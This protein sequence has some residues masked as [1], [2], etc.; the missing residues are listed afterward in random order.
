MNPL[1][2]IDRRFGVYQVV[3]AVAKRVISYNMKNIFFEM[4]NISKRMSEFKC[5]AQDTWH[6]IVDLSRT[7]ISIHA[8]K[9][10]N[11]IYIQAKVLPP[12]K[13]S[14]VQFSATTRNAFS[15][16]TISTDYHSVP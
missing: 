4:L 15:I 13:A 5:I 3:V 10:G 12:I 11:P 1:F 6:M 14:K 8:Q 2:S 16:H 7:L 9:D